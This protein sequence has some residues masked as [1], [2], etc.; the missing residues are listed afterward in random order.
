MARQQADALASF[1]IAGPVADKVARSIREAGRVLFLGMGASHAVGRA[2]EPIY[3]SLGYDAVALPL[4]EQLEQPMPVRDRVVLVTSQSGESA[5]ILRWFRA[6]P[7]PM[8]T[9]GVTLDA[10]SSLAEKVPCLVG[11]GGTERAFAAT[12]SLTVSLALHAAVLARL[13]APTDGLE[14]VLSNP[15]VP[16]LSAA[17]ARFGKVRAIV[18]SGRR[19]QGLA[20]AMALGLAEL[21]RLPCLS[22][23]GGQLRHGPLEM[24]GPEVGVV[25]FRGQDATSHLVASLAGAVVETGAP[26]V[27]FDSSGDA[28]IEGTASVVMPPASCMLAIFRLLPAAQDFMLAFAASRVADVGTPLRSQK[29][30]RIE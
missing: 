1:R 12:R 5:E 15:A 23:E 25:M 26:L 27:V 22:L 2:L 21:S 13:G 16:D 17:L 8:H 24:L 10:T 11:A 18:A 14:D 29:I 6:E 3:R 30:T 19:L 7:A 28:P 9:Y 20:D 4:S